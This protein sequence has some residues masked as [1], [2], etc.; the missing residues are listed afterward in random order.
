MRLI[1]ELRHKFTVNKLRQMS[2]LESN[3][4]TAFIRSCHLT[5]LTKSIQKKFSID[6]TVAFSKSL[7]CFSHEK[8]NSLPA[9]YE[10]VHTTAKIQKIEFDKYVT[11]RVMFLVLATS[12][13]LIQ[14]IMN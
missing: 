2:R 11:R 4:L 12:I 1:I 3:H 9:I 5:I 6:F 13:Y 7:F 8:C 10:K 14:F